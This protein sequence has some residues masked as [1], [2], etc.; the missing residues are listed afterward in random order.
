MYVIHLDWTD[1]I[2]A[3][4]HAWSTLQE[5]YNVAYVQP[6]SKTHRQNGI[7][8]GYSSIITTTYRDY[9]NTVHAA[10]LIV[11]FIDT[12]AFRPDQPLPEQVFQRTQA[13]VDQICRALNRAGAVVEFGLML[14]PGLRDDLD[15]FRTNHKLWHF[16][17]D[18]KD[19]HNRTLIPSEVTL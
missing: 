1:F 18:V 12:F 7:E 17:G 10:R 9:T 16:E 3:G 19:P 4:H 6:Y 13:A 11:E 8:T 2:D 5:P 14:V 15:Y